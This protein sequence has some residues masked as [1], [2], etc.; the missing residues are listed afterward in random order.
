ME[1]ENLSSRY[2][3]SVEMG[4]VGPLVVKRENPIWP[5]PRGGEYRCEAQRRTGP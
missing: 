4:E 1:Q 5:R 2:E 3:R